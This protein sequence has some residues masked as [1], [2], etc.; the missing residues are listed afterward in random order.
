MVDD[1]S[2]YVMVEFLK[3][4]DQALQKV[5]NYFTYLDV[6]GKMPKA[7]RINHGHEFMN[8]S[9]LEWLYSKGMEVHMTAS[10]LPSQNSIAKWMNQTLEDLARAMRLAA[11]LPVFLWE[12]AITHAAYVR[13]RA[14]SSALK[15][16]TPYER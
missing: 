1:T 13:N 9:L 2:R 12:Q 15:T 14:Y 8:D 6:Q 5:K 3:S 11:D 10:Y 7:M 4:K 16:A